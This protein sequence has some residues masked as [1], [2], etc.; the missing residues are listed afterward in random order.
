MGTRSLTVF[1]EDDGTE[2]CVMYRQYDGYI[3]GHGAD[4]KE[5]LKDMYLVN[6]MG[7]GQPKRIANGMDCLTAQVIAHFKDGPGNIYVYPAGT[8]N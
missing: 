5:F 6:G 3:S 7:G 4:L 8:R 2:I 1:K